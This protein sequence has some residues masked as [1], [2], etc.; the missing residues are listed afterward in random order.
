MHA[1]MTVHFENKDGTVGPAV[2]L[3]ADVGPENY[4]CVSITGS[5]YDNSA[6]YVY[7]GIVG[8]YIGNIY[9][10]GNENPVND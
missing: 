9:L 4:E 3:D 10:F 6:V 1:G 2:V 5:V 8:E 7:F